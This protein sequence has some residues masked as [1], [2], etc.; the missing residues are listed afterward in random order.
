MIVTERR[1]H[2][3]LRTEIEQNRADLGETVAAL[4]AKADLKAR[5]LNTAKHTAGWAGTR[6]SESLGW[7]RDRVVATVNAIRGKR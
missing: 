3:E 1:E 2:D 4:A 6:A 7:V 5:L